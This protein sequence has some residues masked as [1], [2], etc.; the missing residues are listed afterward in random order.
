MVFVGFTTSS[1]K[2]LLT[3][4]L[5]SLAAQIP[6]TPSFILRASEASNH[7]PDHRQETIDDSLLAPISQ[8]LFEYLLPTP[9]RRDV[10]RQG[11]S[12]SV[13][14]ALSF[15]CK[16]GFLQCDGT[17]TVKGDLIGSIYYREPSCFFLAHLI[18]QL[19]VQAHRAP[20]GLKGL[21]SDL[22]PELPEDERKK[23]LRD[24]L[25][26]VLIYTL[27]PVPASSHARDNLE[28]LHHSVRSAWEDWNKGVFQLF[29][30][31]MKQIGSRIDET[32]LPLSWSRF[33]PRPG[34]SN[35]T[36]ASSFVQSWLKPRQRTVLARS[37]FAALSGKGDEFSSLLDMEL[38][39]K[40]GVFTSSM[41]IPAQA[42]PFLVKNAM[43]KVIE[44]KSCRGTKN[45]DRTAKAAED[46][47][48]LVQSVQ[49]SAIFTLRDAEY[50]EGAA[51]E[52]RRGRVYD[53]LDHAG[54][55]I[56]DALIE[57]TQYIISRLRQAL[58]RQD[59]GPSIIVALLADGDVRVVRRG[60]GE[61]TI[62]NED[63]FTPL[64]PWP[65]HKGQLIE[66][67]PEED[68]TPAMVVPLDEPRSNGLITGD[69]SKLVWLEAPASDSS[70]LSFDPQA[71]IYGTPPPHALTP[72]T[73]VQFDVSSIP[74]KEKDQFYPWATNVEVRAAPRPCATW[75]IYQSLPRGGIHAG[76]PRGEPPTVMRRHRV[77]P[78]RPWP[79]HEGQDIEIFEPVRS[80]SS[81]CDGCMLLIEP[82][83]L[84]LTRSL[85]SILT[86]TP[87]LYSQP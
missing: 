62:M 2:R 37:L 43:R 26:D 70:I 61:T 29:M 53:S 28:P 4:P 49:A 15:A 40:E 9:A 66:F 6:T 48:R 71:V 30:S 54:K 50:S 63:A 34:S 24:R 10:F 56:L 32:G 76:S 14:L 44:A 84:T 11:L 57:T 25:V 47:L 60:G 74:K 5:P 27:Q 67:L 12:H 36:E 17:P 81:T 85:T 65:L 68:E 42:P 13:M 78:L 51:L 86:L 3:A 73:E 20:P 75:I 58:N 35:H 55:E 7:A 38:S 87:T 46:F 18:S 19:E 52:G 33:P 16:N 31:Y 22:G 80:P 8:P 21:L 39:S 79:L 41:M 59:L 64:D 72:G 45:S 1:A 82:P 69:K 77:H 83:T 23:R